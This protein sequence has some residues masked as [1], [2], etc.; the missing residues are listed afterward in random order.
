[1][2]PDPVV[3]GRA[4]KKFDLVRLKPLVFLVCLIPAAQI[5]WNLY[6]VIRGT[7]ELTDL[8]ANP[9]NK[10]EILTGLWTLRFLAITLAVTPTRELFG[11]GA[12]AKYRR[13]F[14]LFTF[15]Y[16]CIHVG[17]WVGV[18]WYFDWTA[19]ADEIVKHK[20]ILVGMFTFLTLIPLA[21]TSTNAMVRRLGGKRWARLHRLVY[22]A[23]IGGTVHYLWAVK[24]DTLFPLAYV[25][26][27]SL[28]LGYRAFYALRDRRARARAARG[29]GTPDPRRAAAG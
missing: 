5:A 7:A 24:K 22:L 17:M 16:A 10:V 23:A 9:I 25:A 3:R 13:M 19:M 20:Y 1:M 26:T 6:R 15:F 2:N 12:L 11:V 4:A 28:L 27:F 8:G 18:D 14:G 29:A 21:V